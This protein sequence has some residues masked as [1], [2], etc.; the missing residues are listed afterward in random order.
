M[1]QD[2]EHNLSRMSLDDIERL[3]TIKL[4]GTDGP[5]IHPCI[6]VDC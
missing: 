6:D 5:V 2:L 1:F 4:K 3:A